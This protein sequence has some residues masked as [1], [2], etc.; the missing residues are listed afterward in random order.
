MTQLQGG[1]GVMMDLR[2][3]TRTRITHGET[4]TRLYRIWGAMK[5]RCSNQKSDS[6][7]W[8]GGRGIKV[9]QEWRCSYEAFRDWALDSGYGDDTSIDRIDN[10]G[11]Y[12]PD[13]CRWATLK[14]QGA[15]KRLHKNND[16]G[17]AGVNLTPSG[18]Y[19]VRITI[20]GKHVHLGMTGTLEEAIK[21]RRSAEM[22]KHGRYLHDL[23]ENIIFS[24][25]DS[26]G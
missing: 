4:G 7:E 17:Y 9:C 15:N 8:Y 13:N 10:E 19:R 26:N 24:E 3:V 18:R 5:T 23:P 6:Y 11:N 2:T 20:D 22:K 21:L 16:T 12:E 1:E 25:V 14:E